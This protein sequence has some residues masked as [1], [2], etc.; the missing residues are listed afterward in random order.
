MN[1]RQIKSFL[2]K[3]NTKLRLLAGRYAFVD[4]ERVSGWFDDGHPERK[5]MSVAT[6]R[7]KQEWLST[8]YHEVNHLKQMKENSKVYRRSTIQHIDEFSGNIY[9]DY[10]NKSHK[11]KKRVALMAL[12]RIVHLELD[13][14]QK[15]VRLMK[16]S[17]KF[18]QKYIKHYIKKSNADLFEYIFCF[19]YRNFKIG[20]KS[21]KNSHLIMTAMP[22]KLMDIDFYF[23]N[24][25]K[26]KIFFET[27][28][29]S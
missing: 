11:I 15:T 22:D 18:S 28:F 8:L 25:K 17:G 1:L 3:N 5:M 23:K 26:Y 7:P 6:K 9:S 29:L 4:N 14:E 12:R 16:K 27:Y 20:D 24:F 2:K 19:Y 21:T 13:C 10:V